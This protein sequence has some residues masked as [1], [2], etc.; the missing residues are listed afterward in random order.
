[1][2][3]ERISPFWVNGYQPFSAEDKDGKVGL[4]DRYRLIVPTKYVD[5]KPYRLPM[6]RVNRNGD[7]ITYNTGNAGYAKGDYSLLK[8][9]QKNMRIKIFADVQ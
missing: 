1:M 4:R 3:S 2:K 7:W 5:V 8:P 6:V 9:N